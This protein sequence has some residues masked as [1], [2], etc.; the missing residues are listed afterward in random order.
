MITLKFWD[1][2]GQ[3]IFT[4]L[5]SHYYKAALGAIVVCDITDSTSLSSAKQWKKDLDQKVKFHD[6]DIPCILF[7]NKVGATIVN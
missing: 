5:T 7:V 6:Q 2:G 1:I 4:R 3:A